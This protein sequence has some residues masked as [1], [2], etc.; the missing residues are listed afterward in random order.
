MAI[1]EFSH[2]TL[3]VSNLDRSS[4]F[5]TDVMGWRP[6]GP[7]SSSD[8][9]GW[10]PIPG[11]EGLITSSCRFVRDGQRVELLSF[12]DADA[13]RQPTRPEVNHLGLSH[14]TVPTGPAELVMQQLLDAGVAVRRH[15]LSTFVAESSAV[16]QFLFEDPDG[17]IIET[18]EADDSWRFA[19]ENNGAADPDDGSAVG[20]RHL[21]HW[22]Y[23]V[24]D[25]DRSLPFYRQVLDWKEIAA[26]DWD[27]PGPSQV[28]DV[29]PA[30][31][32]TWL[33]H[34]SGQRIEIIHFSDPPVV[35][36]PPLPPAG[37]G[38]SH[39]TVVVSDIDSA[40]AELASIE[41]TDPVITKGT[42]ARAVVFH[43]PDGQIIRA[44]PEALAWI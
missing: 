28:M 10:G 33:L 14:I 20:I 43:D 37:L 44:V 31:L 32:T 17:N 12:Q 25:P 8:D 34:T 22:S 1:T 21:S 16:T 19:F 11:R 23:C 2:W 26:L 39:M 6:L 41:G 7:V 29:G 9:D 35:R 4:R 42:K 15:T 30:R 18:Y 27:G 13:K 36:R 3:A 5:Y 40:F 38:L 24:G